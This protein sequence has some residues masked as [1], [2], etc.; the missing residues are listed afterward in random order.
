MCVCSSQ[1]ALADQFAGQKARHN[2]EKNQCLYERLLHL[3]S[4]CDCTSHFYERTPQCPRPLNIAWSMS[5]CVLQM[6][7]T[8]D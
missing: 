5:Q 7:M 4:L 6:N 3:S 8:R 1:S 2:V